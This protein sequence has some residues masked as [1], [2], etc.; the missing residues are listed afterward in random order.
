[1]INEKCLL[2]GIRNF[3]S[4]VEGR[5]KFFDMHHP[6]YIYELLESVKDVNRFREFFLTQGIENLSEYYLLGDSNR[7]WKFNILHYYFRVVPIENQSKELVHY[8][9]SEGVSIKKKDV[10]GYSPFHYACAFCDYDMVHFLLQAESQTGDIPIHSSVKRVKSIINVKNLQT[11]ETPLHLSMTNKDSR[12]FNLLLELGA[13]MD[14]SHTIRCTNKNM[15]RNIGLSE[16]L[17]S[18]VSIDILKIIIY[19][20]YKIVSSEYDVW[21][22]CNIRNC[23]DEMADIL[24][25]ECV[26]YVRRENPNLVKPEFLENF[27]TFRERILN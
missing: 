11:G 27:S 23:S 26:D 7:N 14:V 19:S 16:K 9:L 4:S 24:F 5:E 8:F 17:S 25:H 6:L 13:D 21:N 12:I 18:E 1:M 20:G 2:N 3:H 22:V 15:S 10:S